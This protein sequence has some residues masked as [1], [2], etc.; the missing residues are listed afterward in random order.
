MLQVSFKPLS[1][2]LKPKIL[3]FRPLQ[4][5][6]KVHGLQGLAAEATLHDVKRR[7]LL[8]KIPAEGDWNKS[9]ANPKEHLL[10]TS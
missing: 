3:S 5:G 10:L 4:S 8:G 6:S 9:E 2:D 1:L 7:K